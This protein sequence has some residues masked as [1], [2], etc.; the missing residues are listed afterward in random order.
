MLDFLKKEANLKYTENGAVT[1]AASESFCLDLFFGAGAMR[2]TEEKEIGRAVIRAYAEDPVKT[3]KIIFFA[4]DVRG[5]LGERRFFKAAVKALS[6]TAPE[7][8]NRNIPLFAEYGRYDDLLV[9]FHTPCEDT[10]VKEIS[11]ILYADTRAMKNGEKVSL[12]AKWL[13]SVNT[14][15]NLARMQGKYLC[16]K[17]GMSEKEY[18]KTLS[19]LRTYCDIIENRLRIGDYTFDYE[20]QA[21]G[22]LF[23]YRAAFLRNDGERY[24]S[25]IN[26]VCGGKAKMNTSSLYPYDIVRA[27]LTGTGEGE[28]KALDAAWK[29]LPDIGA[30]SNA[31]A[32]VDG[33]GSMTWSRSGAVRPI[34]AA[35]SLGIYFAGHNKGRFANHFITFSETPKLVE[36]KGG[37]IYEKTRYC[38]SFNEVANTN[39]EA[40]FSLILKTA[41]KNRVKQSEMPERLYIISDMEFDSCVVG[42]NND[43]MFNAMKKQ[44]KKYGYSLPQIVFWN[45]N[46][47][48][49]NFPVTRAQTGAALVS[50]FTP[51]L[52]DMVCSGDIS[53]EKVMDNILSGE[54]YAAVV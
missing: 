42:G 32:V 29:N 46:A 11:N 6:Y 14:S 4:R 37:D 20:K 9:L 41:V 38:A 33:S 5:G 30:D 8:V 26:A 51:A 49:N 40:V 53:P 16:K 39:L 3:L 24:V 15:S 1:H 52:F 17:L 25:Y 36:I 34:D 18:R 28:R 47:R 50:G 22:A 44:Y 2:G 19:A 45:V 23:K 35:L 48:Q 7:A 27:C 12:I 31:L 54:R 21:S 10:A 43:T 13:P